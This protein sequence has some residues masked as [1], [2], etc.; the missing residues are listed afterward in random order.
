MNSATS[1]LPETTDRPEIPD[2]VTPSIYFNNLIVDRINKSPIPKIKKL[3]ILVEFHISGED[4]GRWGLLIEHG[5]A[6]NIIEA[7][8]ENPDP[9]SRKPICTFTMSG[10]TFLAIVRKETSPQKAFFTRKVNVKGD[11]FLA[12]KANVLVNYL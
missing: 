4:G 6:V 2:D 9:Y 5:M 12:L 7:D 3:N 10:K 11:M 1:T 8:E